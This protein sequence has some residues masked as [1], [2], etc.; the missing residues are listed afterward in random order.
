MNFFNIY[1]KSE[2]KPK[3]DIVTAKCNINLYINRKCDNTFE[4][5]RL[6]TYYVDGENVVCEKCRLDYLLYRHNLSIAILIG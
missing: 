3:T 5:D 1:K 2:K 4:Y 6:S